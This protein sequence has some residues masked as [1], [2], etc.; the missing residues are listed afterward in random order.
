MFV[1][2]VMNVPTRGLL[3]GRGNMRGVW[4]GLCLVVACAVI[5]LSAGSALAENLPHYGKCTAKAGGKYKNSGC[6]KLGKTAEEMKFEWEPLT[7]TVP[8]SS[9][10]EKETGPAALEAANGNVISCTTQT[11]KV[12]EYGPGDQV[13]N[14]IGEF[15]GC[16]A[17]TAPCSSESQPSGHI[18]TFK[19]HGE[20]G[21]VKK[22][23]KT[24]KNIDG[25]DLRAEEEHSGEALLA[26][27]TCAT[28]T[29]KVRG[30]VVVKAQSDST[31][32]T[33]GEL[34]N[35]M[36]NKIEVEFVDEPKGKQIPSEWT[37][38]G[39]GI[40]N[41]K[42]EKIKEVLEGNS[43]TGYEESGQFLTTVQTSTGT[44]PKLELRQ[45]EE[46]G[47]NAIVC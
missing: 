14:I 29:I 39:G 23:L 22:E 7:T 32:G 2:F 37:P 40:S 24:E 3:E 20:P 31:G 34:T 30:G 9:A 25:S 21:I 38:N 28:V 10:K 26:E 15:S 11:E 27:F 18:N 36:A 8:F 6:T 47:K 19:L 41:S 5:A 4:A 12:G 35:K 46:N 13:K 45:C 42:H 33:T 44:K 43:G 17:F 1:T 16:E